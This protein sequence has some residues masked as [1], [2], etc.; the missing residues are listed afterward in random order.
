MNK[1]NIKNWKIIYY[2]DINSLNEEEFQEFFSDFD[3][4]YENEFDDDLINI[5][6][7]PKK[8][9]RKKIMVTKL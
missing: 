4:I 2:K 5:A 9:R 1:N 6:F 8:I 3:F 7:D